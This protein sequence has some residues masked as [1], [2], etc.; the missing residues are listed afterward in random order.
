MPTSATAT[1]DL[2]DLTPREVEVAML[3]ATGLQ[4]KQVA[5]RLGISFHTARHH[6]ERA[7]AKLGVR[8]RAS[9]V[10]TVASG[11]VEPSESRLPRQEGI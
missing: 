10:I 11:G 8:N 5:R 4:T 1:V 7:Y 6:M 3:A 2:Y 9:L